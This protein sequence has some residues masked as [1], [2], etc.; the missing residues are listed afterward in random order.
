MA[1]AKKSGF[2]GVAMGNDG[3][4]ATEKKTCIAKKDRLMEQHYVARLIHKI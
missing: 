2:Y 4:P 3:M 1:W